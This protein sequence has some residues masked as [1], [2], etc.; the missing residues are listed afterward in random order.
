MLC[1]LRSGEGSAKLVHVDR[2]DL[3]VYTRSVTERERE[4]CPFPSL[5]VSQELQV[6][7]PLLSPSSQPLTDWRLE[8]NLCF[9]MNAELY[10]PF[11][12]LFSGGER[13]STLRS[14]CRGPWHEMAWDACES[15]ARAT[16]S[17]AQSRYPGRNV[18]P[19]PLSMHLTSPKF[20]R[21]RPSALSRQRREG[22]MGGKMRCV[23]LCARRC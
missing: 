9:K 4:L 10:H 3:C 12:P 18:L 22:E 15:S 11:F 19:F 1:H 23:S 2:F 8:S 20:A 21:Q 6:A 13:S 14:S 17:A 16:A 5:H 7:R